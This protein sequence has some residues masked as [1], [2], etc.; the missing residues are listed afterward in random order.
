MIGGEAPTSVLPT[1]V[2][3]IRKLYQGAQGCILGSGRKLVSVSLDNP[4]S[5]FSGMKR[6]RRVTQKGLLQCFVRVLCAVLNC[7]KRQQHRQTMGWFQCFV[8]IAAL[9]ICPTGDRQSFTVL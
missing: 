1:S 7:L 2:F 3:S 8:V 6:S 4:D 5:P 9:G